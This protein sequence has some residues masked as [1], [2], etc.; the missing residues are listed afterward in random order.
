[1]SGPVR[2]FSTTWCGH[3][4]RLKRQLEEAGIAYEEID[5]DEQQHFG[6]KIVAKSGGYRI[7]P[8]VEVGGELL[9]NPSVDEVKGALG[10]PVVS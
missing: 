6:D 3:C 7:V 1:M 2:L 10:A 5:L 4:R 8:T 9:I